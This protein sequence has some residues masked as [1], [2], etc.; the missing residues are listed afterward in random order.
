MGLFG[1]ILG[2]V[3]RIAGGIAKKALSKATHG[4]SDVVLNKL[5][6]RGAAKR[7]SGGKLTS[8][9]E[10]ALVHKVQIAAPRMK[11][12][13]QVLHDA[14]DGGTY[15]TPRKRVGKGGRTGKKRPELVYEVADDSPRLPAMKALAKKKG[16]K[17]KV[18]SKRAL[19]KS[20]RQDG[21]PRAKRSVPAGGLDLKK[22]SAMWKAAGKPG[23]WID[24]IKANSD[25]RK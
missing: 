1:K 12:T 5:K 4:V 22:I 15:G 20:N 13:E 14:V 17:L 6:G 24:F 21:A 10:A 7:V 25:V 3:G 9:Q 8:A 23:T 18:L 11:R 2:G 16:R 19:A